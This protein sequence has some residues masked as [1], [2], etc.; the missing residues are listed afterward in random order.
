MVVCQSGGA[1][2]FSPVTVGGWP[3]VVF[4]CF[5]T[6]AFTTHAL[7][8]P[9]CTDGGVVNAITAA[10]V[11]LGADGQMTSTSHAVRTADYYARTAVFLFL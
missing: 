2:L 8:S 10:V 11:A 7:S 3:G 6:P 5:H 4:A 9:S 1:L